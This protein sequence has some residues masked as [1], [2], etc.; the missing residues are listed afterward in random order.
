MSALVCVTLAGLTHSSMLYWPLAL[1]LLVS[2]ELVA[3]L[4]W[5]RPLPW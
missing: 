3:V 4:A 1:N 2:L 5:A